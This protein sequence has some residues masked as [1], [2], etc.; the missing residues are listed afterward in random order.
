[1]SHSRLARLSAAVY[2]AVV[3]RKT[4]GLMKILRWR[5]V[6]EIIGLSRT[7]IWRLEKSGNFP[8]RIQLSKN[9]VGWDS[10]EVQEWIQNRK[11]LSN[12]GF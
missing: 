4:G 1:M 7:Q 8:K 5:Q 12:H 9:S 6:F 11:K 3:H 2:F 10:N